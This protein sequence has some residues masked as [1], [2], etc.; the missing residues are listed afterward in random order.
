MKKVYK[1][2]Q[3]LLILITLHV[4]VQ[5]QKY[6][7]SEWESRLS[8]GLV[9]GIGLNLH[10]ADFKGLDGWK[11]C[12]P[13]FE[14]GTG[15][16]VYTG[17]F[18][19]FPVSSSLDL[20]LRP[21]LSNYSGKISREESDDVY[22][23]NPTTGKSE[24]GMF[25]HSIDAKLS[26]AEL[27][28]L[29]GFRMTD[30]WRLNAGIRFGILTTKTGSQAEKLMNP[31]YGVFLE[32]DGSSS[33]K[34]IRNEYS[35]ELPGASSLNFGLMLG[36]SYDLP[37]NSSK[38]FLIVP[39]FIASM[40]LNSFVENNSWKV[41]N[42]AGGIGLRYAPRE[43]EVV[44][45]KVI[46]PPPP[47]PPLP[48]PPPPPVVPSLN[49]SIDAVA[50]DKDNSETTVSNIRVE[51]FLLNRTHPL[52]NYIFFDEGKATIPQRYSRIT[53]K[54]KQEFSFKA[55]YNLKTMDV[56]YQV[57][58]IVG[59]RMQ[60]YPQSEITLVGCNSDQGIEKSNISLS[61]SRAEAIRDYLVGEWNIPLNRI[62]IESKNL[63]ELPSN[64]KDPNGIVEN[65][66]VEMIA[67]IPDIFEPMIIK[68]TLRISNPPHI[69][70]KPVIKTPI[71]IKTWKI[72]TSQKG[73]ILRSFEG[74]GQPP[75][76]MDWEVE[77]ETEQQFVPRLE[78]PLEY[79]MIVVDNDNK[80][81][82]SQVQILP[83]TQLTI[84]KKIDEVM[85]DKEISKFSIIN[86]GFG[87]SDLTGG[88]INIA[89]TAKKRIRKSSIVKI[90]GY[91]DIIGNPETNKKLSI[92]R[93]FSVC[94]YLGVATSNASGYG[95]D[96][97]LYDNTMPE[98]RFYSRTVTI[99]IT[100][101]IE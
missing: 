20:S 24:K 25:E 29:F 27:Q 101:P 100:T 15:S 1:V 34:R 78:E 14:T 42:F 46:P 48:P 93:A 35:G 33:G 62:K 87:K 28:A 94:N 49:A 39:E 66:R 63:P 40:G 9:G 65:R 31:S 30:Q 67:N 2:L 10:S 73:N 71:G 85:D 92:E 43:E 64:I 51:E 99:D 77:K 12:C 80:T 76:S 70:F 55:F 3:I 11:S 89:E 22:V 90:A 88:N 57:L 21:V 91:S 81:L 74:V 59:K 45:V 26:V 23:Y 98:G 86:F 96:I 13:G 58:N 19:N 37:L 52:L 32:S 84:Q 69:R 95:N 50:V 79:R 60:F 53:E 38:T 54:E 36:T 16:H 97:K 75:A 17:L 82:E 7:Q 41:I 18:V 47:P 8:Y 72:I 6:K 56:Y 5:A 83:V 4:S 44:K 68:D 61:T